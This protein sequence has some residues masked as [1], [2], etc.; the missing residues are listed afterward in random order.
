MARTTMSSSRNIQIRSIRAKNSADGGQNGTSIQSART[1][2]TSFMDNTFLSYLTK[3]LTV[4]DIFN[5][6]T[7]FPWSVFCPPSNYPPL[8]LSLLNLVEST[9]PTVCGKIPHSTMAAFHTIVPGG[10]YYPAIRW[11]QSASTKT[12]LHQCISII[13]SAETKTLDVCNLKIEPMSLRLESSPVTFNFYIQ[14]SIFN[15]QYSIFNIQYSNSILKFNTQ[16]QYSTFKFNIQL[17]HS[18]SIFNIQHSTFN[19]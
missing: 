2:T 17:Q 5:G 11:S 16:I 1:P 4:P 19:I 18:S 10:L 13:K 9:D 8:S 3:L 6:Q 15:I 7:K 14:Y 12:T